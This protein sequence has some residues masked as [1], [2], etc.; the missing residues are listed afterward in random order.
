MVEQF[1]ATSTAAQVIEGHDLTGKV[2]VV[3]G[4]ASGIGEETARALAGAGA[5]VVVAGRGTERGREAVERI[6]AG[7]GERSGGVDFEQLDL[8]S[9]ASVE[10][11]AEQRLASGDPLHLLVNNAG[12]MA[13][14][15]SRT[16]DGFELQFGT[17]H[18]GH[19][20][21]TRALLPALRAAGQAR[22]VVVSSR[23]HRLGDV[24]FGDPNYHHRSYDPWEAYGQSKTANALFAVGLTRRHAAD[25]I[26]ANSLMP[27]AIMTNLQRHIPG[28][29]LTAMGWADAD[30]RKVAPPGWKT[31]E[32]GAATSVWAA[33]APELDGLGG[34]YLENCAVAQPWTGLDGN[35]PNGYYRPYA[36][37]PEHAE[38]LW[39]LSERLIGR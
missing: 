23:A 26:T 22:V 19:F 24:D 20:A 35:V 39:S 4:G 9:L 8:G 31:V 27:G 5:R 28:R 1:G 3:T 30:G 21:L 38:R 13:A 6:R 10:R 32:Q 33:V 36:V 2:A 7:A 11:F 12:V 17:N 18:L 37:D 25:G 14:P 16:E 15:L 29:E 34:H